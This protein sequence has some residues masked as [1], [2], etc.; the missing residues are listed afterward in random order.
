[1][2][3]AGAPRLQVLPLNAGNLPLRN[4]EALPMSDLQHSIS[5]Q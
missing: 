5:M 3:Q 1:M 2:Q 4:L